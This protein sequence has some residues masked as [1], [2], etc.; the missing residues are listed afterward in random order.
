MRIESVLIRLGEDELAGFISK[1]ALDMLAEI[2]A[3]LLHLEK[4]RDMIQTKVEPETMLRS[5]SMRSILF[6]ALRPE[7]ARDLADR[8]GLSRP[9]KPYVALCKAQIRRNS[10]AERTLFGF[11]EAHIPEPEPATRTVDTEI[12]EPD[13]GLFPHQLGAEKKIKIDL[14]GP[15]HRTML[16]MPTG[17]GKTRTAMRIVASYL[18][19]KRS[20]LVVW[21]S[22]SEELCEQAADEFRRMWKAAGDRDVKIVHFYGRSKPDVISMTKKHDGIFMIAGLKKMYEAARRETVFLSALADRASLVVMDEAHQAVAPTYRFVLQ[23]LVEKNMEGTR[24]L[25]LSATPGRTWNDVDTDRH[26]SKF[27]NNKKVPIDTPGSPVNFLIDNGYIAKPELRKIP[28]DGTLTDAE[29]KRIAMALDI[30]EDILKKLAREKLRNL[31][32]IE[33][34][35]RLVA[36]GHKRIILFA[37][38]IDHAR[39]ISLVLGAGGLHSNYVTKDTQTTARRRIIDDYRDQDNTHKIL[40]NYGILTMGFD[41]P[42]TSAVVIARPTKSLV[43]Y[44]QM[45][46]RCIRGP[47]AKGNDKCTVVTVADTGRYGFDSVTDAFSNWDDVWE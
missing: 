2:N 44:S 4:I 24:L 36:E 45:V 17:S 18:F 9:G 7:E 16:H 1:P 47:K 12:I 6:E 25:G 42:K 41:A 39:D 29:R 46:G 14:E 28:H 30:P 35:K 21:L 32:I 20:S 26:L 31:A 37:A 3:E 33:A 40:C 43:L 13:M 8:L 19:E 11:F 34:V 15:G 10:D 27:F 5:K 23:T 22:Y 38:T